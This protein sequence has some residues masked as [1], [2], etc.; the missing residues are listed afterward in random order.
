MEKKKNKK[1]II[2]SI[3]HL[4]S[5]QFLLVFQLKVLF[6]EIKNNGFGKHKNK[7]GKFCATKKHLL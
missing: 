4:L 7:I 3:L 5:K 1:Q 2:I 6:L